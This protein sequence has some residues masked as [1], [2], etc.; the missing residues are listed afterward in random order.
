M[1]KVKLTEVQKQKEI[2]A[3]AKLSSDK[4]V[5]QEINDLY[6]TR[7]KDITMIHEGMKKV[8]VEMKK[9]LVESITIVQMRIFSNL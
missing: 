3:I 7:K 4:S 6:D 9:E 8:P 1:S 5:I 2:G